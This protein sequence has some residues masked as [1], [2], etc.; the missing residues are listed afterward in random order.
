MLQPIPYLM[1][2]G[3]CEEAMR[4]Y[5]KA[6]GAKLEATVRFGDMPCDTPPPDD[7][8]RRVAH[9]R[10]AFQGM[11]MLYAG[12]THPMYGYD[13]I[14]GVMLTLNYDS[15][16][17]AQEAFAALSDGGTVTMPMAPMLWAEMAGMVTDRYGVEWIING[18]LKPV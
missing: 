11:G 17:Q 5:E 12:D 1:F 4:Y 15:V 10:L 9:A 8:A 3:N 14:K 13:G 7:M 18:I 16:G 6:L 2:N